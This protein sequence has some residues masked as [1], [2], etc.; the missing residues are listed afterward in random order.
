MRKRV[1]IYTI[2]YGHRNISEFISLLKNYGIQYLID[3]RSKPSSRFNP[4]FCQGRNV[5]DPL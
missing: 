4:D 2:G 3:V 1:P 5:I